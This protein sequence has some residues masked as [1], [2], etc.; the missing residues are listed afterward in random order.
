MLLSIHLGLATSLKVPEIELSEQEAARLADA[1]ARVQAEF[2]ETKL[3]PRVIV[4]MNLAGVAGAIYGQR[5]VAV[6]LRHLAEAHQA[7]PA[8]GPAPGPGP[9]QRPGPAPAS[10]PIFDFGSF[11]QEGPPPAQPINFPITRQNGQA[12]QAA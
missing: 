9:S 5:I 3:P 10:E 1:I 6:R 11:G 4:L 2:P 12:S 7:G 8:P